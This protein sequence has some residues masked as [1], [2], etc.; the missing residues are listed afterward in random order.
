M[1]RF[2]MPYR[3]DAWH[4][5]MKSLVPSRLVP[6]SELIRPRK[7]QPVTRKVLLDAYNQ[8]DVQEVWKMSPLSNLYGLSWKP[9]GAAVESPARS[10]RRA[11]VRAK[12]D[13]GLTL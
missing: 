7:P 1:L 10:N 2:P 12:R 5:Q 4:K 13:F 3:Q 6:Q 8:K 9:A 11:D